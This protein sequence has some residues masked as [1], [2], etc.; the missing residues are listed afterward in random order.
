MI[1]FGLTLLIYLFLTLVLLAVL[2][3][4]VYTTLEGGPIF[5]PT[6]MDKV[7][8]MLK[9][10][11]AGQGSTVVDLGSGD[12]R[13]LIEAAKLGAKAIGYEL[14]PLLVWQ[15]RK[16][17]KKAGLSHLAKV[18]LKSFWQAN[19]NEATIISLYLLPQHMKKMEKL[20]KKKLN[21][22]VLVVS[23]DYP[24]LRKKH[25]EK[26]GKVYLYQFP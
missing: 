26:S 14:D 8:K 19:L 12:G 6:P 13:I 5:W 3:Y 23:Y 18:H 9:M 1:P 10:A 25:L 15:S 7:K 16:K 4:L 24:F 17:I 2:S 22:S 20:L 21:H 11:K